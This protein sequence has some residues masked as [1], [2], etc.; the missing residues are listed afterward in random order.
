MGL[1]RPDQIHIFIAAA[2]HT[3]KNG[4][5][6]H[7]HFKVRLAKVQPLQP[8]QQ[9]LHFLGTGHRVCQLLH[10]AVG[11]PRLRLRR[12]LCTGRGRRTGRTSLPAVA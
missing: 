2:V 9:I 8:G 6:F 11:A 12:R 4:L 1:Q 5:G 3:V 10:G 7:H